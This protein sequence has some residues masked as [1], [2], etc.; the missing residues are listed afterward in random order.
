MTSGML[1]G[2]WLEQRYGWNVV[3]WAA[4]AAAILSEWGEL[5]GTRL[6]IWTLELVK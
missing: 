5:L 3:W 4:A 6:A 2:A 1:V